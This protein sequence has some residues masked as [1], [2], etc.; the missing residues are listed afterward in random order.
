MDETKRAVFECMVAAAYTAF[1]LCHGIDS[2]P[3]RDAQTEAVFESLEQN[4]GVLGPFFGLYNDEFDREI[5]AYVAK[6][7]LEADADVD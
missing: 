3:D 7:R 6:L 4:Y 2:F 5:R 1:D